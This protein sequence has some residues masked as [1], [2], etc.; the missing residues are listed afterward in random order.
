MNLIQKSIAKLKSIIFTDCKTLIVASGQKVGSTWLYEILNDLDYFSIKKLDYYSTDFAKGTGGF[1]LGPGRD[2]YMYLTAKKHAT[3]VKTHADPPTDWKPNEK[4]GI[5]VIQRDPRNVI[6]STINYL[7]W[8]PIEQGG[9]G[10]E[11][12]QLDTK[13]KYKK[14][15]ATEWHIAQ[16]EKWHRFEEGYK[17][18][19]ESLLRDPVNQ[20]EQVLKHHDIPCDRKEIAKVVEKNEFNKQK[21]KAL[22]ENNEKK[23]NFL[24]KGKANKWQTSF[25][26]EMKTIFKQH[27]RWNNLLIEQGYEQTDTW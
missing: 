5:V 27:E 2:S 10:P 8:L 12:A 24:S 3:V 20:I 4:V 23:I 19:Y 18:S 15:M 11:F 6:L 21:K 1:R 17:V 9:W 16:L 14:F 26:S 25:D 22:E 13:E 7:S